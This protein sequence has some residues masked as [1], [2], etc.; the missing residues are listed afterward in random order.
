MAHPIH[1]DTALVTRLSPDELFR[2]EYQI[3]IQQIVNSLNK[4]SSAVGQM[5]KQ[6]LILSKQLLLGQLQAQKLHPLFYTS[7][8]EEINNRL[9]R[10]N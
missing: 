3:C 7:M 1:P 6:E 8:S 2:Q 9:Q 10:C 5:S 4:F